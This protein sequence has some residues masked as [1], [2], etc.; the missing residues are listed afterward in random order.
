MQKSGQRLAARFVIPLGYVR[1][2]KPEKRESETL[3]TAREIS[4]PRFVCFRAQKGKVR[5]YLVEKRAVR[6]GRAPALN[7]PVAE[8][9]FPKL[10]LRNSFSESLEV[11]AVSRLSAVAP[12]LLAV[13]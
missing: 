1:D 13:S 11:S 6:T 8:S 3:E 4:C 12:F 9:A 7:R 5:P 2:L 10:I